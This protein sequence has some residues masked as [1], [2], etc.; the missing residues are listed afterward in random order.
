MLKNPSSLILIL[1]YILCVFCTKKI[2]AETLTTPHQ[3]QLKTMEGTPSLRGSAIIKN[4]L[5]VTGSNNAVFVSQDGGVTWLN[6]SI[7]SKIKTDFRDIELFN[8]NTAIVMGIGSGEQSVLFKTI[9]GGDHWQ[10][11]YQNIH[12]EGFYDSIAFW[13]EDIG[14]LMGDPIDGYYDIQKTIDGGKTWRRI[15]ENKLPK[16]LDNESAFAASGNTLI[17][18]KGGNAWLTTGGF[19]A[20]VYKSSDFGETWQ[21]DNVPLLANYQTAGG[22]GLALNA[23]EQLFVVGGDYLQRPGKYQNIATFSNNK[24]QSVNSGQQ[25]LRTAMS[26]LQN[27]CIATGKTSSDISF[28]DG[29]TWQIFAEQQVNII[30]QGF[31]TLA[32]DQ[33]LFLA[34]GA[35]G[36]VGILRVK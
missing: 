30:D 31:Y 8:N 2:Y 36:K 22:Y 5:W 12:A 16:F 27:T 15:K 34:A 35:D 28:D 7:N 26:C 20:S 4:S 10:L 13:D 11:L 33:Q 29:K 14:L 25:G 21:R 9:D 32:S 17:V 19:S 3:W 23:Q 18:G 6:K 1:L 24:W